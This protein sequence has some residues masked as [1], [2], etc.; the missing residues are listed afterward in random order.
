MVWP[1][2][3]LINMFRVFKGSQFDFYLELQEW[4]YHFSSALHISACTVWPCRLYLAS[5][6]QPGLLIVMPGQPP[7][8]HKMSRVMRKQNFCLSE[9]KGAD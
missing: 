4:V 7:V 6:S 1:I 9:K 2:I 3:F 5:V 8:G